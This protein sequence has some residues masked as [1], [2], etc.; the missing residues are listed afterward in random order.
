M[1]RPLRK[2]FFLR[3][4]LVVIHKRI[5]VMALCNL[6]IDSRAKQPCMP[7]GEKLLDS[8]RRNTKNK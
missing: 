2:D 8:W 4:P 1:A 7:S 3:L 5:K 6:I